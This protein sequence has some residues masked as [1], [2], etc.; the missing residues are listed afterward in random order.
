MP[1]GSVAVTN[2]SGDILRIITADGA[3]YD[4]NF[5]SEDDFVEIT[6]SGNPNMIGGDGSITLTDGTRIFTGKNSYII[7]NT[8][9]MPTASDIIYTFSVSDIDR[10]FHFVYSHS[11]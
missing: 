6:H 11:T 10:H 9:V 7:G 1:D 5:E 8:Q 4:F 2:A 3:V